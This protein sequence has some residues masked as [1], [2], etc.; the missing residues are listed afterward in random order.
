VWKV[1]AALACVAAFARAQTISTTD[2]CVF[3]SFLLLRTKGLTKGLIIAKI[4]ADDSR[5]HHRK[6]TC[7]G[8]DDVDCVRDRPVEI[9]ID[10]ANS[11]LTGLLSLLLQNHL[12]QLL[13]LLRLSQTSS[14]VL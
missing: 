5:S 11:K 4:W 10:Q 6:S 3:S 9:R 12:L 7:R 8:D 14:K 13:L 1:S 2:Q